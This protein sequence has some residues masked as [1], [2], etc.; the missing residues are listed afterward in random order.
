MK[1]TAR[2][3]HIAVYFL[4][5]LSL[6]LSPLSVL[7][8]QA[9]DDL[10]PAAPQGA[11]TGAYTQA[12]GLTVY[13][14]T[15]DA[16]LDAAPA[17]ADALVVDPNNPQWM[18]RYGSEA[19]RRNIAPA[20]A[21]T[22]LTPE[23]P[24]IPVG[25][26]ATTTI[27]AGVKDITAVLALPD[28]RIW[29]GVAGDG[30]RIYAPDA[31]GVYSW[32][33]LKAS[34]GGLA[35]NQVTALAY[36]DGEIW[37]GT[38]DAGI[39]I[40]TPRPAGW[41]RVYT[42]NSSLPSDVIHRLTAADVPNSPADLLW[43]STAGGAARW[44][45]GGAAWTVL[46]TA[47]GLPNNDV[48]DVGVQFF[49][50]A[51][52]YTYIATAGGAVRW[53][54]TTMTTLTGGGV[55]P[56][57][58]AT[59]VLVESEF[60][61]WFAA[62][63]WI[64]GLAQNEPNAPQAG[65]W[66]PVG[67]C[68]MVYALG[69]SWYWYN[70]GLGL[71]S[72]AIADMS[73]DSS[74]RVWFGF[75]TTGGGIKGGLV[76]FDHGTWLILTTPDAPLATETVSQVLAVGE[77]VWAGFAGATGFSIYSPN[78]EYLSP[79]EMGSAAA[80]RALYLEQDKLW[81]AMGNVL[82][83]FNGTLWYTSITPS[84]YDIVSMQRGPDGLLWFGTAGSGVFSFDGSSNFVNE[85]TARGLPSNDV[86]AVTTD[87]GGRLW[88]ATAGGLAMRGTG[89]WLGF[90][91]ANSGLA[92]NNVTSLTADN[93]GR[94]WA[95]T[96]ANGISVY[97]TT[98]GSPAWSQQ[99]TANGLPSNAISD[100]TTDPVGNIWAATVAG[101]ARWDGASWTVFTVSDGLP[102]NNTLTIA[103]D[104]AGLMWAGTVGGVALRDATGWRGFHVTGSFLG[105]DRV[106]DVVADGVRTWAAAGNQVAVRGIVTGPIGSAPP[107]ISSFTPDAAWPVYGVVTLN[108]TNFDTRGPEYNEVRFC[109]ANG[110]TGAPAPLA[111]IQSVSSTQIVV[112]VPMLAKSGKLQVKAH[113]L[114]TSSAADF[115]V[116]PKII[117]VPG[118]CQA[119]GQQ[120]TIMGLGFFGAGDAAAYVK[121]GYGQERKADYQ[122]PGKIIQYIRPGDT[123]GTVRVRLENLRSDI[124]SS[125]VTIAEVQ[126][127]HFRIQQAIEGEPMVW[128]KRTLVQVYLKHNG[129]VG[130]KV[131]LNK[132]LI[133]WKK[134][135]GTTV[136]GT[137]AYFPTP[138][139][140][141]FDASQPVLDD[142]SLGNSASFVAEFNTGRSGYSQIFPLASFDGVRITLGE[143]WAPALTLD[144]GAALFDYTDV[145]DQRHILNVP[146]VP[147]G[148]SAAQW[149]GYWAK[150]REAMKHVARA[151]PQQDTYIGAYARNWIHTYAGPAIVAPWPVYLDNDGTYPDNFDDLRDDVDDIREDL[152]DQTCN[153]VPCYP[154]FDQAMGIVAAELYASGPSGKAIGS[155]W[156]SAYECDRWSS[157]SFNRGDTLAGTWLQEA[158]HATEWVDPNAINHDSGNPSHSKYDEG[159][160]ADP[161]DVNCEEELSFRQALL[162]QT[163]GVRRVVRLDDGPPY[164]YPMTACGIYLNMPTGAMSYGPNAFHK[165]VFL[166]PADQ[167]RLAYYISNHGLLAQ[168]ATPRQ[169]SNIQASRTLRFDGRIDATDHVTVTMSAILGAAGAVLTPSGGDYH[170]Q[171]RGANDAV[172]FEQA[173]GVGGPHTH[174][175]G[176]QQPEG[177]RFNLRIPFP[178][179]TVKAEIRHAAA[180]LWSDVVSANSPT[181][182]FTAPN[183]GSYNAANS[184]PVSWTAADLDDDPLHFNLDYTPD[185]GQ[186]WIP[187]AQHLT[188]NSFNWTPNFV[189]PSNAGRLR[190]RASDGFNTGSAT[191]A[192]FVL[193]A[194]PP[195]ALISSPEEGQSFTEGMLLELEGGS[196]T[197]AGPD[198][199][200]FEWKRGATVLGAG[201]GIQVT[202]DQV[203]SQTFDL[204]VT[205]DSQSDTASVT[206]QVLPDYDRDGMPN[207]WELTYKFDPLNPADAV[208]NPDNDGLDNAT[209]HRYGTNPR[210]ADTDGDG[211]SDGAEVDAHT[212]PLNPNQ[213]PAAG[214]VLM[215][216]ASAFGFTVQ[217]GAVASDQK[218][219]WITNG[220]AG[221]LNWSASSDVPWLQINPTS[222][223][224]PTQMTV[225][226][227][228]GGKVPATYTGHITVQA[229]GA[230][231]S[232]DT[233]T[234]TLKIEA[235][236]PAQKLYLP[237]ITR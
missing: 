10:P 38:T 91:T 34:A 202:L 205:A 207:D 29:A 179:G 52:T 184:I 109:C 58:R 116:I 203:G 231:G 30:L 16:S 198:L 221:S 228:P 154:Y 185:H 82:S 197:G 45:A 33:A 76:A 114:T 83:V 102:S 149:D 199:G 160:P 63:Q 158:I 222:G 59:R 81:V 94:I 173:F 88:A 170:L 74:G 237:L 229:P 210:Q 146:V 226:A 227:L 138:D 152:N 21:P 220:G 214:P 192:P 140:V 178:D 19:G 181:V 139:G 174:E 115:N 150:V 43:A 50:G 187:V 17:E 162:D 125:S 155:C 130:C 111:K 153:G 70:A 97:D 127:T 15:F 223:A 3:V 168:Q 135:D 131:K 180:L 42:G 118:G 175:S 193:T 234:V 23:G 98:G 171:L 32:T 95:G 217:A 176:P 56:M 196:I 235:G 236:L 73:E 172:L 191:S 11:P 39:S 164:A 96:A 51:V 113:G 53:N 195:I 204:K 194:R 219:F 41:R 122:E 208:A 85:T 79:A 156:G 123:S 69:T 165:N 200:S 110:Q 225:S 27:E 103:S 67:A 188:G 8:G 107:T 112:E 78:W 22:S 18:V 66:Q 134:K 142:A 5:L 166:E 105:A 147:A 126:A 100:L 121:I 75:R 99:T 4:V 64:P 201:R 40:Y 28:G 12:D 206:I 128:G 161:V 218:S 233:I 145:G 106:R 25:G 120:I 132:G 46:T 49:S 72:S 86:R 157:I 101:V 14:P 55:C 169:M 211:A 186:S 212:D 90:T 213:K 31:D 190:L 44:T 216:G 20:R 141:W 80:P 133:D 7:A 84:A 1:A 24:T 144:L 35:S 71:P 48:F 104:P 54:G 209:E 89:Y 183:G 230:A 232:P 13:P 151:Y 224:A 177:G 26:W 117:S 129:P 215:T 92:S 61:T 57:D 167:G 119:T 163:G 6:L 93:S 87:P 60:T 189:P 137:M 124:S 77:D 47:E 108:G 143:L 9:R 65:V 2:V 62:E 182:A 37:V 136:P 148:Y 159:E 36:F 68:R